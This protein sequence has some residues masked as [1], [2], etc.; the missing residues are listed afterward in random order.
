MTLILYIIVVVAVLDLPSESL[1]SIVR[2]KN[3]LNFFHLCDRYPIHF[4]TIKIIIAAV[5]LLYFTSSVVAVA[6]IIKID[7]I[8]FN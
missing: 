3:Y 8:E 2:K 7:S 6:P 5:E 4:A 1:S